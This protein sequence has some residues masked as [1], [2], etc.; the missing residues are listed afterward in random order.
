MDNVVLSVSVSHNATIGLSINGEVKCLLSEERICRVKNTFSWPKDA[1]DYAVNTYL[2]GDA[3]KIDKV[4][5][6]S[7]SLFF[8]D[9]LN[10][11]DMWEKPRNIGYYWHDFQKSFDIA[12]HSSKFRYIYT[13]MRT[14]FD[15]NNKHFNE[16]ITR[17]Y[18]THYITVFFFPWLVRF[19]IPPWGLIPRRLRRL[20]SVTLT[21]NGSKPPI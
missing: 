3:S 16:L 11:Y 15:R 6:P 4:V 10:L 7:E 2:D 20:E 9:L 19:F 21:K 17:E 5:F 12:K 14:I 18:I 13:V 1:I 8:A